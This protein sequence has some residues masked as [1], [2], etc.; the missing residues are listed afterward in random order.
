MAAY[1]KNVAPFFGV[2]APM[3]RSATKDVRAKVLLH[4]D[5]G[6]LHFAELCFAEDHRELH[7]VA[8]DVLDK[9]A[10]RIGAGSLP[11]LRGLIQTKSWWDT[12][13]GLAR[14]VGAA[15]R[16]FPAWQVEMERW[17]TDADIWIR[18][19]AI[20]HQL[21]QGH[22]TDVDRLFR[23]ILLNVGDRE[24]FIRKAIGWALRDL[25][26][27]RPDVVRGFV[28]EHRDRLSP[29]SAREALKNTDPAA[30]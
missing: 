1:M 5:D 26:W 14:V 28:T 7:Y 11:R 16:R 15:V 23:I 19:V 24:F 2:S 6:V 20:L 12:V 4:D 3:R 27:K 21:G 9:W 25:A 17:A 18:R 30:K 13:D 10:K 8:V 22:S 29:L